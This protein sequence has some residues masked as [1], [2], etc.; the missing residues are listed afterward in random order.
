[1]S[2]KIRSLLL[3]CPIVLFLSCFRSY[4]KGPPRDVDGGD[5]PSYN[6]SYPPDTAPAD[7]VE[8]SRDID[9][10]SLP[11]DSGSHPPDTLADDFT[12]VGT[13]QGQIMLRY[14]EG[15]SSGVP[16]TFEFTDSDMFWYLSGIEVVRMPYHVDIDRGSHQ[17]DIEFRLPAPY[18]SSLSVRAIYESND[19]VSI[20]GFFSYP[21][22][23]DPPVDAR[24]DVELTRNP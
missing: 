19:D 3:I 2:S 1:M 17:L 11:L 14:P 9:A 12:L 5:S 21:I 23:S 10:G 6:G 22:Q 20:A 4:E 18:D 13:W 8:P 7:E 24:L 16:V 15:T